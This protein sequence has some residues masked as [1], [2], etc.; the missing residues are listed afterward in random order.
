M[1]MARVAALET[2]FREIA[3]TR[4]HGLPLLN[5]R[6]QVQAIAFAPQAGDDGDAAVGV[7]LTPWFMNLVRLPAGATLAVGAKGERRVGG[8]VF[9]FIGAH[10]DRCGAFEACSLFSPMHEF[11]DQAAAVATA[12]ELLAQLRPA[13]PASAAPPAACTMAA[14]PSRRGFLFGR[15]A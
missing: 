2:T 15:G 14:V 6:L 9:E 1:P 12:H 5:A 3:A 4:F 8:R 10:E 13:A 7:L 11:A